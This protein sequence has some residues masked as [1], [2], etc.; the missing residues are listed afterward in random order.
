MNFL[1]NGCEK[2]K[3]FEKEFV[4]MTT[5]KEGKGENLKFCR[6]CRTVRVSFPDIYFDG[7]P[8][9][10]LANDP[11]TDK[12]RVF[13]SKGQKA[14]YLKERG[15]MEAGD[16]HHGAPIQIHQNQ[17]KKI[18]TRHEVQMALKKVKEMGR[19]VRRQAYL[20]VIK[21]GR[22]YEQT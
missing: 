20:K 5:T 6:T 7:K 15:I 13:I 4:F 3:N 10:N 22:I 16:A 12:P 17:N 9:E 19:D 11:L 1:C 2:N 8:E 14:T 18:N 21:E